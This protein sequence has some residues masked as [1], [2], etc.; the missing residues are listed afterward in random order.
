MPMTDGSK[1]NERRN[2][3]TKRLGVDRPGPAGWRIEER[4]RN[5]KGNGGMEVILEIHIY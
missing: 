5:K 2:M 3:S 1:R 4:K